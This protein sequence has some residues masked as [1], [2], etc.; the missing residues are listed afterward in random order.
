MCLA[1][2][3]EQLLLDLAAWF[4]DRNPARERVFWLNGLA[5]TGK[6]T[7]ARTIAARAREQGRLAAAFFFSRN[8]AVTRAP[9][10]ILPTIA[11]QLAHYQQAFRSSVC[12]AI[13][14]DEDVSTR[15]IAV[16]ARVLFDKMSLVSVFN[17]PLLI[18][19]DA[20]DEC[21]VEGSCEGG[22]AIPLLLTKLGSLPYIKIMI[23]SRVEDTI[24]RMFDHMA[25]QL[26]LHDIEGDIVRG[27]IH[28]YFKHCLTSLAHARKLPL[29]FPTNDALN[30]LVKRAGTLFIYAATVVKWVSD[31]KTQPTLRLQQV[32]EQDEYEVAFQHRMLDG[33]YIQI[34]A[35]A[36]ET[37]GNPKLHERALSNILSAIVLLQEPM[38]PSSLAVLV[39][40][41]KRVGSILPL[42][43]AV[44]LVDDEAPVRLF[45]PSFPDFI[46]NEER[47][48][49]GRFLVS[50]SE[51]HL[52]LAT[53]CLEIMNA[54][55]RRDICNIRDPWVSNRAVADLEERLV[56]AVPLELRY[57]CQYWHIH[58]QYEDVASDSN[59]LAALE[60]FCTRHL[61]HW[62]ELIS[63]LNKLPSARV[64]LESLLAHLVRSQD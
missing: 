45:H 30:E 3:R 7:V 63:L 37:T 13:A 31:P 8:I 61:L 34:L 54:G 51:G 24:K 35:Q 33:M 60:T 58:L 62:V 15:A 43:S 59:L 41:K 52:R 2:T 25:N 19:L 42:L 22:D 44:L 6:T 64:E 11:Y 48:T 1:E 12:T 26:A 46:T 9:S 14:S 56:C 39:D 10:V 16:Q 18:V 23:T 28:L 57:A 32:L 27:D 21:Y 5:G 55:L 17:E 40:E 29:P 49:D 38:P 53:R 20:L 50:H 4:D 47:C 36:A